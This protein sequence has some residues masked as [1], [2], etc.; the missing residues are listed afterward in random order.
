MNDSFRHISVLLYLC[1]IV[2]VSSVL[3]LRCL[4]RALEPLWH[5]YWYCG[6]YRYFFCR[7]LTTAEGMTLKGSEL[8]T[9]KRLFTIAKLMEWRAMRWHLWRI[10]PDYRY[11]ERLK[12]EYRVLMAKTDFRFCHP[13]RTPEG[14][15]T[16]RK[17][18]DPLAELMGFTFEQPRSPP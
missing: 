2:S 1:A 5:Y 10:T 14:E 16:L 13:Q 18:F 7:R 15:E 12:R 17:D 4:W 11:Y 6:P 9:Y 3:C 8:R